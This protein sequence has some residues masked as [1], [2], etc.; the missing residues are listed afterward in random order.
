MVHDNGRR[1]AK[2]HTAVIR[3]LLPPL[4]YHSFIPRAASHLNATEGTRTDWKQLVNGCTSC[5]CTSVDG[6]DQLASRSSAVVILVNH[7]HKFVL[8]GIKKPPSRTS[9]YLTL[10]GRV[11]SDIFAYLSM[12]TSFKMTIQSIGGM[13]LS[14]WWPGDED[15]CKNWISG[16]FLMRAFKSFV[17]SLTFDILIPYFQTT[18]NA[19][20]G[21]ATCLPT[22]Q[23]HWAASHVPVSRDIGGTG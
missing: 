3:N 11:T 7:L 16:S 9:L 18:T 8:S 19:N 6:G 15:W 5:T 21:R 1:A 17:F 4:I 2:L 13:L 14:Q 22:A 23:T 20:T 12:V 10:K